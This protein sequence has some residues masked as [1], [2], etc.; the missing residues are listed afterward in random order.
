MRDEPLSDDQVRSIEKEIDAEFLETLGLFGIWK[1][2]LRNYTID[3]TEELLTGHGTIND[4]S[5]RSLMIYFLNVTNGC[6]VLLRQIEV[7]GSD[8]R[9]DPPADLEVRMKRAIAASS[10][11]S[12][13]E[14][15]YTSY[16][17]G[18]ATAV[19]AAGDTIRFD[20]IGG[21]L[22]ARLRF[23]GSVS[24][25]SERIA[26]AHL[27]RLQLPDLMAREHGEKMANTFFQLETRTNGRIQLCNG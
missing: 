20:P 13:V 14:D 5:S 2:T 9:T 8:L 3:M 4:A 23:F 21:E 7:V 22:D 18:Y 15:A 19:L 17:R 6:N 10:L 12:T 24:S 25:P 16:S 11:Y 27:P 1:S 26:D